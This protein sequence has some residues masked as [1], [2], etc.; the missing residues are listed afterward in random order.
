MRADVLKGHLDMLLLAIVEDGPFHGYAVIEEL[1]RRTDGAIDLPEGTIYPALHRLER[2]GLLASSWS[3]VKGRRRRSYTLTSPGK[4]A[5]R[6]K[7]REWS[8]FALTVQRVVGA[9]AWPTMA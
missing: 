2:A 8:M 1:R 5:A 4:K 9:P 7:R 6:E 3:E